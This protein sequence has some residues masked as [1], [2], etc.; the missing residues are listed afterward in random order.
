MLKFIPRN[1]NFTLT[2]FSIGEFQILIYPR[3]I[4]HYIYD[5]R[6]KD[7]NAVTKIPVRKNDP[8]DGE[9]W[10]KKRSLFK[11]RILWIT[12][13]RFK[14]FSSVSVDIPYERLWLNWSCIYSKAYTCVSHYI[15]RANFVNLYIN[16]WYFSA[17]S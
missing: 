5:Q 16:F 8:Y 6:T 11:Y 17:G 1:L 15:L 10:F 14:I 9:I 3:Q 13:L 2:K 4:L 12:A 7:I